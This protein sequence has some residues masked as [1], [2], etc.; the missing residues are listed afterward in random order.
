MRFPL[1]FT[2]DLQLEIVA[3][4]MRAG[5]GRPVILK[6]APYSDEGTAPFPPPQSTGRMVWIGGA[7]PLEHPDI[8]RYVNDLA[9][10]NREVFLHTEGALL[11]RRIHEFQP[12][13]RLRFVLSFDGASS[14]RNGTTLE[15]IRVAKLSGFL[16]CALTALHSPEELDGLTALHLWLHKLDL[17]GYIILPAAHAPELDSAVAHAQRSLLN[18]QWSRV[19]AIFDSAVLPATMPGS[20]THPKTRSIAARLVETPQRDFEEG[21]QAG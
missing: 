4:V 14:A 21:A 6:L 10:L 13:S 9:S 5:N 17:D 8:P 7:E 2:A 12:S 20:A 18:R 19:S 3:R 15:A 11:R 16:V 1:R